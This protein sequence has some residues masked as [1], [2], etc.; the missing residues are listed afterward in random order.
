LDELLSGLNSRADRERK[1][2]VGDLSLALQL[3]FCFQMRLPG[4]GLMS[5]PPC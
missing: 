4:G 5:T 2:I 3:P 1:R